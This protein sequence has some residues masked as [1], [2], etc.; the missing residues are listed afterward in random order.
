MLHNFRRL[1]AWWRRDALDDQLAEEMRD[2]LVLRTQ[3]LIDCGMDPD[4]A[5]REARRM[6]GNVLV[7]REET[8]AMWGFPRLDTL[9]QDIR[10][11]IR[12]MRRSPSFTVVAILSLAIGIGASVAVFGL[13]DAVLFRKLPVRDPESLVILRW[14]VREHSKK[15]GDHTQL[16]S[17]ARTGLPPAA[18]ARSQAAPEPLLQLGDS[19]FVA[20]LDQEL[21]HR[22]GHAEERL[23]A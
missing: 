14:E 5:A 12:L 19:R 3:S 4:A 16:T 1:A 8:R 17:A 9:L 18:L 10:F 13:A 22:R 6:F 20:T 11:G 7:L 23:V 21:G 15:F 2:H